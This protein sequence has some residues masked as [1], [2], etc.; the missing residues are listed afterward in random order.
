MFIEVREQHDKVK[1]ASHRNIG[2]VLLLFIVD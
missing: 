1:L 2:I